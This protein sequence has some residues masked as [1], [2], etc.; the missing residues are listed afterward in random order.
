MGEDDSLYISTPYGSQGKCRW[1]KQKTPKPVSGCIQL[2]TKAALKR[3]SP[4]Y[5]PSQCC[6]RELPGNDGLMYVAKQTPTGPFGQCRWYKMKAAAKVKA[7]KEVKPK[8]KKEVKPKVKKEVKPKKTRVVE[9]PKRKQPPREKCVRLYTPAALGGS[10][11]PFIPGTC[12]NEHKIGNDG[13]L[14]EADCRITSGATWVPTIKRA[15]LAPLFKKVLP[16]VKPIMVMDFK[17]KK[18]I[19]VHKAIMIGKGPPLHHMVIDPDLEEVLPRTAVKYVPPITREKAREIQAGIDKAILGAQSDISK[20]KKLP[21]PQIGTAEIGLFGLIYLLKQHPGQCA[22]LPSTAVA[23]YYAF[24]IIWIIT[25]ENRVQLT[26]PG[27]FISIFTSCLGNPNARFIIA[28]LALDNQIT[29]HGHANYLIYDKAD[30]TVERFEPHG[31]GG[32][33]TL[34]TFHVDE[35]DKSL[36]SLFVD[37]W[38]LAK[39]YLPPIDFCPY[40]GPQALEG[41]GFSKTQT[42]NRR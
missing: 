27:N 36:K 34:H 38:Q 13:H 32:A 5:D 29:G 26:F 9:E 33:F 23:D 42:D 7:K 40:L 4:P 3:K 15:P 24:E 22:I 10:Q 14:Y 41:F 18:Q 19:P 28:T 1:I 12:C 2:K 20:T 30:E 17:T 25:K 6:G 8:V 21:V 11:P 39:K 31:Y 35:L 16:L 37:K